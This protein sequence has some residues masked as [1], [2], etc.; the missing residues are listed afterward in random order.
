MKVNHN[1]FELRNFCL[2]Y[3]EKNDAGHDIRHA[4]RV[5]EEVGY[6][7]AL[8]NCDPNMTELALYAAYLHDTQVHV[9]RESHHLLG[10]DFIMKNPDIPVLKEMSLVKRN[11]IGRAVLEHRASRIEDFY[12]SDVSILLACAD[13]GR[14]N[15]KESRRRC[16][17]Y[18]EEQGLKGF[19]LGCAVTK[20]LREKYGT[21]GYAKYPELYHEIYSV[22]LREFQEKID[23]WRS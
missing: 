11:M 8:C 6:I 18:N 2:P 16:T 4:D 7:A 9:D 19:E 13:K 14:P 17:A 1:V 21:G 12:T 3:Y 10:Y 20:H 5:A 15:Y 22:Q 23:N